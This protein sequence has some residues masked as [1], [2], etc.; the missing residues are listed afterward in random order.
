MTVILCVSEND[1]VVF[2]QDWKG[3]LSLS[4]ENYKVGDEIKLMI[5]SFFKVKDNLIIEQ[6]D[7]VISV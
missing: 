7:F 1:D 3:T 2:E 6:T 5:V 4:V